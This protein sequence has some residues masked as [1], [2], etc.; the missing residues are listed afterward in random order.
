MAVADFPLPTTPGL[1]EFTLTLQRV[2]TVSRSPFTL[3][4]Q[5][6]SL[7]GAAWRVEAELPEMT[8]DQARPWRAFFALLQGRGKTFDMAIPFV[9]GGDADTNAAVLTA[10]SG[11]YTMLINGLTEGETIAPGDFVQVGDELKMVTAE[12]TAGVSGD[13]TVSFEPA[14][15]ATYA[16]ATPVEILAPRGTFRMDSDEAPFD[17]RPGGFST[18][19]IRASEAF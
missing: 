8:Q 15:R 1:A 10:V 11:Q 6:V 7:P 3:S 19:R 4:S 16:A 13:A 5:A 12:A 9:R 2:T 18:A 17:L 14:L